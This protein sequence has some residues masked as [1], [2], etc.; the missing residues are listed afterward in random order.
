MGLRRG[1]KLRDSHRG[2]K[3]GIWLRKIQSTCRVPESGLFRWATRADTRALRKNVVQTMS[4]GNDLTRIR[5]TPHPDR[6]T[7]SLAGSHSSRFIRVRHLCLACIQ[8]LCYR[9]SYHAS[10]IGGHQVGSTSGTAGGF[11]ARNRNSSH[12]RRHAVNPST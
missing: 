1:R 7:A 2:R 6:P 11:Q 5:L 9:P 4:V 10:N 3:N 12:P 8:I